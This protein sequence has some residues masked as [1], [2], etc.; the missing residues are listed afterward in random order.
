M[1]FTKTLDRCA[2]ISK[3]IAQNFA[4]TACRTDGCIT[5]ILQKSLCK[6]TKLS[7]TKSDDGITKLA[8]M[9]V[10]PMTDDEVKVAKLAFTENRKVISLTKSFT[11]LAFQLMLGEEEDE[12]FLVITLECKFLN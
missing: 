2:A 8:Y 4:E 3:Q 11:G 5:H 9:G 12:I 6:V 7:E 1:F 10:L